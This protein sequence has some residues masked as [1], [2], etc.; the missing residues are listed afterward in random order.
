MKFTTRE[1]AL[2]MVAVDN[3]QGSE[4]PLSERE[5]LKALWMRLLDQYNHQT[6][7]PPERVERWN[8]L[9]AESKIEC[10]VC[11]SADCRWLDFGRC[12]RRQARCG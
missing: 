9:V 10:P 6:Q 8:N 11:D 4:I 3:V 2:L 7:E 5:D 1:L 12:S